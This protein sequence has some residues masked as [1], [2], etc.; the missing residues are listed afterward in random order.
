MSSAKALEALKRF[1]TC[2][3]GDALVKLN[4]PYGGYLHGLKMFSP[5]Y[6]GVARI[7]GP[8]YTVQMVD[9]KDESAPKPKT[10]FVDG[11]RKD[12]V[13]FVSQPKGY[14][15]ACWGG[16]MS[17]RAKILGAK[18]VIIDGNFRDIHEH[19]D[20]DFPL[21][22]RGSSSLGSNTFTRSAALDVPVRFTSPK[23]PE[24][25]TINPGDLIVADA[26]GVVV[27]PP[28]VV[29][30]CVELCEDR[31][32]IDQKTKEALLRGEEMG[33]TIARLRK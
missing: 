17:T 16:L 29:S 9:A 20:L 21:F 3:I 22:A 28:S 14:F 18:G 15:S 5:H 7:C 11:V 4:V 23:R 32:Q 33:Q 19:R 25:I 30:R 2:D 6:A 8:A 24:P 31:S 1:T 27:V 26:D 10:H 12:A 13:I